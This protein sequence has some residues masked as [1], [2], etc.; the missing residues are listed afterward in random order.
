MDKEFY[1]FMSV[2]L[3]QFASFAPYCGQLDHESNTLTH[4]SWLA[5]TFTE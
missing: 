4:H 1:P 3:N 2:S 5:W